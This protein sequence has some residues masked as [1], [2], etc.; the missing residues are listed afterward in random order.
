M[1]KKF[2]DKNVMAEFALESF[3]KF[4]G[5]PPT[6]LVDICRDNEIEPQ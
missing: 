6:T 5:R 1:R 4:G 3:E 2:K